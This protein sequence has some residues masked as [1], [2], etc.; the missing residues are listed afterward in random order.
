ML[1]SNAANSSAGVGNVKGKKNPK[2]NTTPPKPP[3][4][5]FVTVE[6]GSS[7]DQIEKTVDLWF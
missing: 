5:D 2:D 6:L 3:A 4:V 7:R 1:S